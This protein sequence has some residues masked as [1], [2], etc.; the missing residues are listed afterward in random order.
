[1]R[2]GWRIRDQNGKITVVGV[3]ICDRAFVGFGEIIFAGQE[4]AALLFFHLDHRALQFRQKIENLR[5]LGRPFLIMHP[6]IEHDL[7][8]VLQGLENFAR[9]I[10]Q[11]IAERECAS[12]IHLGQYWHRTFVAAGIHLRDTNRIE[13][14][15][16]Y[17][18]NFDDPLALPRI[19]ENQGR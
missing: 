19:V 18:L 16:N 13:P 10:E 11:R 12:G 6:L 17:F 3:E 1:M 7:L 4:I 2:L 9:L 8:F 15:L 5:R 14:L